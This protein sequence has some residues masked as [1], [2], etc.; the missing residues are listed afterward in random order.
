E[1]KVNMMEFVASGFI[2]V[3]QAAAASA[4]GE[5]DNSNW[6]KS[7]QVELLPNGEGDGN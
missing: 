4:Q 6:E 2:R 5:T 3:Y 7:I 1:F